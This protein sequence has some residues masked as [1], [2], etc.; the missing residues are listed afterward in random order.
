MKCSECKEK[1]Q[2]KDDDK[3]SQDVNTY[4]KHLGVCSAE[5][6]YKIPRKKR[7]LMMLDAFIKYQKSK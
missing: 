2:E 4:V 5:C 1:I 3:F 6:F 7:N